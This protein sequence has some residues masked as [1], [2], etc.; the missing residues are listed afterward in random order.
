MAHKIFSKKTTWLFD[1]DNTLYPSNIG[2]FSQIDLKMK[3]FI[4]NKFKVSEEEAFIIQKRFYKKYGT[5]LYGLMK[6]FD[7][8]PEDFLSFVH[9]I[10]FNK[11]KKSYLLQKKIKALPGKKILY[12]NGDSDYAKK[13]L[14]SLGIEKYF[15]DIFDIR[16]ANYIPKPMKTSFNALLKTYDLETSEIVYFDDLNKNLKTASLKGVTTVHITQDDNYNNSYVDFRFRTIIKALDMIIK[17][18][19]G[20]NYKC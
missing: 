10:N 12:T 9:N 18:L 7:L 5:T 17:S 8:D 15:Y 11:L 19:N 1:L 3:Q 2:I 16:R 13:I 6:N 20:N 4:S 14:E